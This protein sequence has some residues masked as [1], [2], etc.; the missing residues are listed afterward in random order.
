[1]PIG[2]PC[3]LTIDFP[4]YFHPSVLST[5]VFQNGHH[6]GKQMQAA[7]RIG[8]IALF[9]V[10]A[11]FVVGVSDLASLQ[12][13]IASQQQSAELVA[14][15]GYGT[16][17]C[18]IDGVSVSFTNKR[19]E[20]IEPSNFRALIQGEI[21]NRNCWGEFPKLPNHSAAR[22]ANSLHLGPNG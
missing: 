13:K 8:V 10:A 19:L 15:T 5:G 4:F 3:P 6:W 7:A 2:L 16:L 18:N 22:P 12:S 20:Q 11:A 1:L 17:V 21:E 9:G 14:H